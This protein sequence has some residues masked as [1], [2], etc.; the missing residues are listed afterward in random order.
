M[1][2]N[3]LLTLWDSNMI[4]CTNSQTLYTEGQFREPATQASLAKQDRH[5]KLSLNYDKQ[6]K[7]GVTVSYKKGSI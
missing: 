3:V 7:K 4:S 6:F 1:P 2:T 5:S